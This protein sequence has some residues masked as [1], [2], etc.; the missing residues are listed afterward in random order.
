MD[1]KLN[2]VVTDDHR[3]FRKGMIALLEDFDFIDEIY[4]A[5]NGNELLELLKSLEVI[6]DI[7]LLDLRMPEMD[8]L[9]ATK[10]LNKLYHDIKIIILTMD[11]DEQFILH[12]LN[13]GINGYLL[14]DAD[15][16]E[17][18]TALKKVISEGFY[19]TE[20]IS[21]TILRMQN[22]KGKQTMPVFIEFT[23]REK[24]VL[25]LV[26]KGLTAAEIAKELALSS[27]TIEGYKRAL[28]EKTGTKNMAGLVVFSIKNG[29]VKI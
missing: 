23:P 17:L 7:V 25:Q 16:D 27:R 28:L 14:K 9:E 8:G 1:K 29:F 10:K 24:E 18:E 4:E 15:P 12:L 2:I 22:K 5:G 26:C 21:K 19:F 20:S 3:L 6:P 11:D 13:E